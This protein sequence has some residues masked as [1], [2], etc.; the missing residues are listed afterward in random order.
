MDMVVTEGVRVRC[1]S[2]ADADRQ[3]REEWLARVFGTFE[4]YAY[5]ENMF[6]FV[7]VAERDFDVLVISGTDARRIAAIVR[8]ARPMLAR[9]IC[10]VL[11]NGCSAKR[12]ASLLT[13]GVDDVFCADRMEPAEALARFEAIRRRYE[14]QEERERG[15]GA[16]EARLATVC[17][18]KRLTRRERLLL[19]HLLSSRGYMARYSALQRAVSDY[20]EEMAPHYLKLVVCLLRRKLWPGVQIVAR[21]GEGYQLLLPE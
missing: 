7:S 17:D 18:P 21:R 19:E 6:N 1:L 13:P 4:T 5:A 3:M 15:E 9:R 14:Q 20:H 16:T 2:L 12:R 10:I 8:A 11:A